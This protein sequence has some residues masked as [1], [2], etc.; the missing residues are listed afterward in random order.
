MLLDT[1]SI[2]KST[3]SLADNISDLLLYLSKQPSWRGHAENYNKLKAALRPEGDEFA[4][5]NSAFGFTENG[6]NA[7]RPLCSKEDFFK[8]L[9]LHRN[10]LEK[11]LLSLTPKTVFEESESMDEES[12][13][14]DFAAVGEEVLLSE[15]KNFDKASFGVNE[16]KRTLQNLVEACDSLVEKAE[17][18]VG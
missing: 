13:S 17:T 8:E 2:F 9:A 14:D 10:E 12:E 15:T 5:L 16:E 7:K 1:A 3:R 11:S 6:F 4:V 18:A